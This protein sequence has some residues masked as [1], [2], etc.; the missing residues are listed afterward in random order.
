MKPVRIL[1]ALGLA[2]AFLSVT[3][4]AYAQSAAD[5]KRTLKIW[6]KLYKE[7]G[8]MEVDVRY[9]R[10]TVL[11]TGDVADEELQA[12]ANKIVNKQR[13][14][15]DVRDRLRLRPPDVAA[16]A[17][18]CDTIMAKLDKKI[19][20]DEELN[21]ARRKYDIKCENG[22]M[23]ITGRLQDYTQAFS[24]LNEIRKIDGVASMNFEKLKY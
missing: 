7:P 11:M 23:T 4:T 24:L 13:G 18:D 6:K 15:K 19:E 14:V 1:L 10:G 3:P 9:M 20:M 8:M 22:A 12:K 21:Q 5:S 17:T 16:G 2:A